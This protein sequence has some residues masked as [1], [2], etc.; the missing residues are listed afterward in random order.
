M[1]A[2]ADVD[3]GDVLIAAGRQ[4]KRDHHKR[5]F[6]GV[7]S[8]SMT[9]GFNPAASAIA[10]RPRPSPCAA[11]ALRFLGC[12]APAPESGNRLTSSAQRNVLVRL[13]LDLELQLF[14][15][16]AAG[17]MI[18]LVIT[19]AVGKA[20]AMLRFRCQGAC[21]PAQRLRH[22]VEVGNM[23]SAITSLSSASMAYRSATKEPFPT[24]STNS[25]D[26][27]ISTPIKGG[28]FVHK[29]QARNQVFLQHG[30]FSQITYKL[31]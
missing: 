27:L 17:T 5:F 1:H 6:R 21:G 11:A 26:E 4:R 24:S 13:G 8:T 25:A 23:P 22:L 9:R 29:K 3:Q 28:D 30:N 19:I 7:G 18:F 2:G 10:T 15:G 20:M 31:L 12:S 16:L 14:L